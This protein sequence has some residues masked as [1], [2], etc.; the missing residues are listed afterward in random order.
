M[1]EELVLLGC[2]DVGPI[3][4]PIER[5]SELARDTLTG[6]DIR[7][8]QVGRIYSERGELGPNGGAHGRLPPRMAA[9]LT[10]CGYNV[11]SVTGNDAMDWGA[12]GL[13]DTIDLLRSMGIQTIGGWR[14]CWRQDLLLQPQQFYTAS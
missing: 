1:N 2:G 11:V 8:A 4:K 9:V 6:A 10:D 13:L 7:F 12:E 5:Y 14:S 3:H